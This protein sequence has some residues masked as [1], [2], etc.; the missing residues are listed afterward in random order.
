MFARSQ[1]RIS[2][3]L[4][5]SEKNRDCV[6]SINKRKV[7]RLVMDA[8]LNKITKWKVH[9]EKRTMKNTFFVN[10]LDALDQVLVRLAS[11]QHFTV[12]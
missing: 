3:F 6:E 11:R 8:A 1:R 10:F 4:S 2:L 9:T 5:N 7:L 12:T